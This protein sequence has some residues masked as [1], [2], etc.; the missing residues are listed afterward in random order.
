[1]KKVIS[2]AAAC[3]LAVSMCIGAFAEG[4]ALSRS[5]TEEGEAAYLT[6]AGE[7]V[8]G[9]MQITVTRDPAQALDAEMIAQIEST[10]GKGAVC[11]EVLQ[12]VSSIQKQADADSA[13]ADAAQTETEEVLLLHSLILTTD[14]QEPDDVTTTVWLYNSVDDVWETS[15]DTY[16]YD[17]KEGTLQIA[18]GAGYTKAAIVTVQHTGVAG[19]L[20]TVQNKLLKMM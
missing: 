19:Y 13:Q 12:V 1:M 7:A 4:A 17:H 8:T 2:L 11:Q 15:E 14:L 9:E 3:V 10:A 5:V 18:L 6:Q 20:R 16:N